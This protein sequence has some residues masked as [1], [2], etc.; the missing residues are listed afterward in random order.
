[1]PARGDLEAGAL[2]RHRP[3]EGTLY[4]TGGRVASLRR[5]DDF[6][7]DAVCAGCGRPVRRR[8]YEVTSPAGDWRLKYPTSEEQALERLD[9]FRVRHP[10]ISITDDGRSAS[11]FDDDG[12]HRVENDS[13]EHLAAYLE[14]KF[15]GHPR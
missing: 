13:P 4:T 6:P 2:C 10:E 14:A 9:D 8:Q 12:P 11:W 1:M 5:R 3:Q 7:V 15:D